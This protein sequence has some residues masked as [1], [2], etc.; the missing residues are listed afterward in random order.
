MRYRRCVV[1]VQDMPWNIYAGYRR[2]WFRKQVG[3][4]GDGFV[5]NMSRSQACCCLQHKLKR[6]QGNVQ[7]MLHSCWCHTR[8]AKLPR[9]RVEFGNEEI[10][11]SQT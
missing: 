11:L 5:R 9:G 2:C 6:F 1:E 4:G 3:G 7:R 8:E 10:E